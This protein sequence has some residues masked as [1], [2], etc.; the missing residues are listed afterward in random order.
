MKQVLSLFFCLA[1][2]LGV[3]YMP[4]AHAARAVML[5][6]VDREGNI[7]DA[8][9]GGEW[10]NVTSQKGNLRTPAPADTQLIE[11]D[12]NY[13]GTAHSNFTTPFAPQIDRSPAMTLGGAVY[14]DIL[15]IYEAEGLGDGGNTA[16]DLHYGYYSGDFTFWDAQSLI[17]GQDPMPTGIR[18]K[19]MMFD[20]NGVAHIVYGYTTVPGGSDRASLSLMYV[21]FDVAF[22]LITYEGN[23][24]PANE[25]G[26]SY[27]IVRVN[28]AGDVVVANM[29]YD[30][31]GDYYFSYKPAG[32]TDWVWEGLAVSDPNGTF[33]WG[34][35]NTAVDPV[36]NDV[37]MLWPSD[38]NGDLCADIAIKKWDYAAEE[39]D[40]AALDEGYTLALGN[41]GVMIADQ[42]GGGEYIANYDFLCFP[43][44]IVDESGI[45]HCIVQG[46][47]HD[48]GPNDD[49]PAT[50]TAWGMMGTSG[51]L[52]YTHTV[53][54][55]DPSEW[56]E[57]IRLLDPENTGPDGFWEKNI[58]AM[59]GLAMDETGTMYAVIAQPDSMHHTE[60]N[61]AQFTYPMHIKMLHKYVGT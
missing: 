25:R 52:Y 48:W 26:L 51:A 20:D 49:Q 31:D 42:E 7:V 5:Y 24:N 4:E 17:S 23:I 32:S 22:G 41:S 53:N 43:D 34:V 46:N 19:S 54:P 3:A 40:P 16:G 14:E 38:I 29:D 47:P 56:T 45:I 11:A 59:G 36:T 6:K 57:P 28:S 9:V 60:P 44:A 30:V 37:Y 50:L 39:W 10:V 27:P 13:F 2:I 55:R 1:L 61:S 18:R 21:T 15:M 8:Q 33:G 12:V 35:V 58:A